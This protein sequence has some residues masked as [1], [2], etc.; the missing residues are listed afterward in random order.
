MLVKPKYTR[1]VIICHGKSEVIFTK[2]M[3]S[4]LRLKI[5]IDSS[6]LTNCEAS[7][8]YVSKMRASFCV[9]GSLVGRLKKGKF[10][11][12]NEKSEFLI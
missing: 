4:N 1:A 2:Y 7:Q 10:I 6:N 3:R 12:R 9:L 5:E 8:E 11:K